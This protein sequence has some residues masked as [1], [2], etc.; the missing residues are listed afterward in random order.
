MYT[1]K[2][3]DVFDLIG[4]TIA[5]E[6]EHLFCFVFSFLF[7]PQYSRV[8][9]FLQLTLWNL[10]ILCS[11]FFVNSMTEIVT[12]VSKKKLGKHVKALVF[13]L[14]CNDETDEDVEVPY[15]RYTI[16]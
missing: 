11:P 7:V 6:Q 4:Y 16:R 1:L 2:V 3:C 15:V 8:T 9:H 14:C 10:D 13:E 12:K 5:Y